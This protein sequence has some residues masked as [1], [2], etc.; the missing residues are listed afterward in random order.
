M[1]PLT[2][3]IGDCKEGKHRNMVIERKEAG[4]ANKMYLHLALK[5]DFDFV[6]KLQENIYMLVF[7]LV[8]VPEYLFYYP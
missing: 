8:W 6:T 7:K 4:R 1:G 3:F 5:K 2:L